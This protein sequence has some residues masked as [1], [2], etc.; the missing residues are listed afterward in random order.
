MHRY[1][2]SATELNDKANLFRQ[3]LIV[4]NLLFTLLSLFIISLTISH[5]SI[6]QPYDSVTPLPPC[7]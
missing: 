1:Q 6:A 5:T 4:Y 2:H 7:P 3:V